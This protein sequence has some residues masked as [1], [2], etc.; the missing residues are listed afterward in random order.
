MF[1]PKQSFDASNLRLVREDIEEGSDVM[2]MHDMSRT[3]SPC[4]FWKKS[5]GISRKRGF[6]KRINVN[7]WGS[8]RGRESVVTLCYTPTQAIMF[9][10]N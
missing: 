10:V 6:S 9:K 1:K 8:L 7:S 4:M 5:S 2:A 3:R